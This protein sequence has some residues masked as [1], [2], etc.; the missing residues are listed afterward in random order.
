M[1]WLATGPERPTER[2]S[3]LVITQPPSLSECHF[4][5]VHQTERMLAMRTD[6]SSDTAAN[7]LRD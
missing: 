5:V 1:Q 2:V 6:V 7:H 4:V 3:N